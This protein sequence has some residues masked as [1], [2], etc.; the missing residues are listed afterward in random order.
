MINKLDCLIDCFI[1][2]LLYLWIALLIDWLRYWLINCNIVWLLY[3]F[4]NWLVFLID[5]LL[6]NSRTTDLGRLLLYTTIWT[7]LIWLSLRRQS[8]RSPSASRTSSTTQ[9]WTST[10]ARRWR[11]AHRWEMENWTT[12]MILS[13]PSIMCRTRSTT[14][15]V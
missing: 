4:I 6:S 10:P 14:I 11:T 3:C 1:D 13:W 8:S 2:W 7:S 9:S 15:L 12:S 5:W